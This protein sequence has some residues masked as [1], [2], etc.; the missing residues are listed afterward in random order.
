MSTQLLIAGDFPDPTVVR[1]GDDYYMTHSGFCYAPAFLI[2]HSRDLAHWT[3]VAHA[4]PDQ[5]GDIWA[6]DL[7]HHDN[8]FFIYYPA[9]DGNSVI[10]ADDIRG[11]WSKPV[12]LKLG[13]IDPG[14][15]VDETGNRFLHLSGGM[16]VP[17]SSDGLSTLGK[18]EKIMQPWPMPDDGP[19]HEGVHLE[20]PKLF[21]REGWCHLLAAQGGTA[22]PATSH[23]VVHARSRTVRGPWEFS[24]FNPVMRTMSRNELWWSK[25]H[26][27]AIADPSGQWWIIAHAYRNSFHT[28]GRQTIR[29]P[30]EWTSDGWLRPMHVGL[31]VPA[32]SRV[33]CNDD[34]IASTLHM[35]WQFFGGHDT[36]RYQVGG[37]QLILKGR[38]EMLS[39]LL[40]N[41][42]HTHYAVEVDVELT[43]NGEAGIT[44]FYNDRANV[45]LQVSGEASAIVKR[46][47]SKLNH[48]HDALTRRATLKVVFD[49]NEVDFFAKPIGC[50]RF[51]R[52]E[53]SLD[54][55]GLHHNTFG[56]FLSL[57]PGLFCTGEAVARF[58]RFRYTPLS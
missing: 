36:S 17:L 52:I 57:R 8:R 9:G 49:H 42:Q 32:P 41:P 4:L 3:P 19:R 51:S 23:M 5:R 46:V 37:G 27:T 12:S 34:F 30:V 35:Q 11:P 33:T 48:I 53:P 31:P 54:V 39:P 7:V 22:G 20:G 43:G 13:W 47:E 38:D 45:A 58:A 44:L 24:P 2:W 14:H 50:E 40:C 55:S 18:P 21:W 26:G 25:G 28:L 56:Q 16:I 29:E 10:W 1:V 6:P 15:V